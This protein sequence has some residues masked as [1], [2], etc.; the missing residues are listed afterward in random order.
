[1]ILQDGATSLTSKTRTHWSYFYFYN[2]GVDDE[3][4]FFNTGSDD[5]PIKEIL[6]LMGGTFRTEM[7][8][9]PS[10]PTIQ[11][12]VRRISILNNLGNSL[13]KIMY[14]STCIRI[15]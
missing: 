11:Y 14:S 6:V 9:L 10:I 8:S 15:I 13:F 3:Q 2:G 7:E 5:T 12:E 1:M 4:S